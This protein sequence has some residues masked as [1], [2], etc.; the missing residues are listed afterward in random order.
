MATDENKILSGMVD[1]QNDD[2]SDQE[3]TEN[4]DGSATFKPASK[5]PKSDEFYRN[6]ADDMDDTDLNTISVSLLELID[7]DKEAR[8]KRDEQYEEGI[9]RMGLGKETIGGANFTGASNVTHPMYTKACIDFEARA[10]KELFPPGGP[11]RQ[12]IPG[13]ITPER[14]D[15]A[16]RVAMWM[17]FQLTQMMPNFRH[18]LEQ[19]LINL[20]MGGNQYQKFIPPSNKMQ[21]KHEWIPIDKMI[22]PYAA[23]NFY[24]AERR[25]HVQEIT[26]QE[27][28]RRIRTGMY[29]DIQNLASPTT[30]EET[31]TQQTMAAIEGKESSAMNVDGQRIIYEC[32]C[33][34]EIKDPDV[35]D[36]HTEALQDDA[37]G[38]E[39]EHEDGREADDEADEPGPKPYLISI[40]ES[41]REILGIYRNW[42]EK[43]ENADRLEWTVEWTFIPFRGAYA[44]GLPQIIGGLSIAATGALR[45]LLDSAHIN[46]LAGLIK[47]KGAAG[48]GQNLRMGPTE[49]TEVENSGEVDDIRKLIM[50]VPFGPPSEV[51]LTLL[52]LLGSQA[53]EVIRTTIEES[54]AQGDVPVGT[55]LARIEQGMVAFS[56]IHGRLHNSMDRL[57]KILHRINKTYLEDEYVVEAM[58]EQLVTQEDFL[59]DADVLPVSDPNIFCE[60]QRYGQIQTVAQRAVLL[61]QIY[62]LR[63]VEE[64]ILKQM[65]LPN[66]GKD[67]LVPKPEPTQMN[68]VNENVA[69]ALGRPIVAFP[70]QDH[71]AHIMAHCDFFQNPFFQAIVGSNVAAI[72]GLLQNLKEHCVFWYATVVHKIAS[73]QATSVAKEKDPN[74]GQIDVG[75]IPQ[76]DE[77]DPEVAHLYDQMLAAASMQAMQMAQQSQV[78]QRATQV[79][80]QLQQMLQ[81]MQPPPPMD[82]SQVGMAQVKADQEKN[83]LDNQTKNKQIDQQGQADQAANQNKLVIASQHEQA[84]TQRRQ[85]TDLTKQI[86]TKEDNQT[87]LQINVDKMALGEKSN[88]SNGES[89]GKE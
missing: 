77:K 58:N 32:D 53:E 28:S 63:K 38:G 72:G 12:Y 18:E 11:V 59:S 42:D 24:T 60:V 3:V 25:T 87:A 10:I 50:P 51:L 74:S 75:D 7:R 34:F 55:T 29:R 52:G 20:P 67:L 70:Q 31:Q 44:L 64:L 89:V 78:I 41:S 85:E 27:F 47:M 71:N 56:A 36:S 46:N 81:K 57:L 37:D 30:P 54:Q 19:V 39:T 82:P 68:P 21:V 48:T 26:S 49:V 69:L 22:L 84:E 79:M 65:K 14:A 9:K 88:V 43:D 83:Q 86:T 66:D 23:T 16:R 33:I 76:S 15:R 45:A 2:E 35:K 13:T 17:N 80:G 62:D 1:Q 5:K 8:H 6:L 40:D 73:D 61:P 4:E